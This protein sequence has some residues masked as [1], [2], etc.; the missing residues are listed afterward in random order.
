MSNTSRHLSLHVIICLCR[1]CFIFFLLA[2]MLVFYPLYCLFPVAIAQYLTLSN[3]FKNNN[4]A[5]LGSAQLLVRD[6]GSTYLGSKVRGY[7]W[8]ERGQKK[9]ICPLSLRC[10]YTTTWFIEDQGSTWVLAETSHFPT[11]ADIACLTCCLQP[12][13]LPPCIPPAAFEKITKKS[14]CAQEEL[15]GAR[16]CAGLLALTF[17]VFNFQDA[18][19]Q[20]FAHICWVSPVNI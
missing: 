15:G 16:C 7:C 2:A 9:L 13:D 1:L 20:D 4:K 12:I 11:T 3:L 19:S 14:I 18:C 8:E 6:S 17:A 5:Y 10:P